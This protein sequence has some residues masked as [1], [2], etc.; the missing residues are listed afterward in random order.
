MR[1]IKNYLAHA[2][3]EKRFHLILSLEDYLTLFSSSI[4]FFWFSPEARL[5]NRQIFE[6]L[7]FASLE[8]SCELA[9]SEG[10]YSSYQGSPVSRGVLQ[11]DMWDGVQ[12]TD[13]HD[14]DTLR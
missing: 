2:S 14:W 11:Q 1:S 10:T 13:L 5:L 4:S 3:M 6:T 12:V 9:A 8:A 7:Y